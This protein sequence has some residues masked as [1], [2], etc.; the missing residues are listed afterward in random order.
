MV[1]SVTPP[2][3][4]DNVLKQYC[5]WRYGDINYYE[6]HPEVREE[7]DENFS[8][9]LTSKDSLESRLTLEDIKLSLR[10]S[11]PVDTRIREFMG[12]GYA[13][14]VNGSKKLI[15]AFPLSRIT[16]RD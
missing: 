13:F 1:G 5:R 8:E 6:Y 10:L 3:K 4:N 7:L 9:A 12:Y 14:R 15:L 11:L 2:R 16:K